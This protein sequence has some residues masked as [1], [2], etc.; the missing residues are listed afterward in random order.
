[1]A[2]IYGRVIKMRPPTFN[3]ER[4]LWKKGYKCVAGIDEAGR[5]PLAGP[6]V[7]AACMLHKNFKMPR[8]LQKELR[9]SKKLSA[10]KRLKFYHFFRSR[11]DVQWGIGS[12]SEKTID[13]INIVQATKL[14]MQKAILQLEKKVGKTDALILDGS[15]AIESRVVQKSMIK[16]D[17]RVVSCAM[18][19]IM[20][21]V[22]RDRA[23]IKYHKAYPLYGFDRH[24]GYGTSSHLAML[25][26]YG[27]CPL[28][29]K[30]FAPISNMINF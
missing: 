15:F 16:G 29:R 30:T 14:A 11:R 19:S 18:A 5:G 23:M 21:K 13:S 2:G 27:P 8:A 22:T 24:K 20:A 26:K 7:A 3:E 17:E 28:H 4:K 25:K 1:M 12:V 10:K 9:D 6:V